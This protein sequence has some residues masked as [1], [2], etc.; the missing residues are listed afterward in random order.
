[1]AFVPPIDVM[2]TTGV[3]AKLGR[4]ETEAFV[5][6]GGMMPESPLESVTA[7][8]EDVENSSEPT[9]IDMSISRLGDGVAE[10]VMETFVAGGGITPE[11]PVTYVTAVL[12]DTVKLPVPPVDDGMN[13]I[14][15][16]ETEIEAV[17]PGG[18]IPESPVEFA[19]N[20]LVL[21]GK[22][23]ILELMSVTL[24]MDTFTDGA[25]GMIPDAPALL[26]VAVDQKS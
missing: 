7:V 16:L 15:P 13:T 21:V 2:L 14:S 10:T 11:S 3:G 26:M 4:E 12:P 17:L 19:A 8:L 1:M 18:M 9:E 5:E 23:A 24:S 6:D 20:V 22:D 25:G